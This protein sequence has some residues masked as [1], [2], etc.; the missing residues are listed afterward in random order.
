MTSFREL[1]HPEA[2]TA[3]IQLH[4]FHLRIP[5][6]PCHR[7]FR[8]A[9]KI[10]AQVLTIKQMYPRW[11][12][13]H[14]PCRFLEEIISPRASQHF[15]PHLTNR[16]STGAH[17]STFWGEKS[18]VPIYF[19]PFIGVGPMS[20]HFERCVGVSLWGKLLLVD[21]RHF[22]RP[23]CQRRVLSSCLEGLTCFGWMCFT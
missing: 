2:L 7:F 6:I 22:V 5:E 4:K 23:R 21:S 20:L 10:S 18:Q 9:E 3:R 1:R 19:R 15:T 14:I 12:R 16:I 8:G 13:W 11:L 17:N